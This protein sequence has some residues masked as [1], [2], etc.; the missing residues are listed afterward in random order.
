M[1]FNQVETNYPEWVKALK[2]M[3]QAQSNYWGLIE[4]TKS[5]CKACAEGFGDFYQVDQA[6]ANFVYGDYVKAIE[7]FNAV[8]SVPAGEVKA[9]AD[10]IDSLFI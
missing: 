2:S 4:D 7:A 1:T 10:P 6:F 9:T 8:E 3:H 5:R